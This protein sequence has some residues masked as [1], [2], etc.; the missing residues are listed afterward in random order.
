M[1]MVIYAILCG[2]E[3]MKY[4]LHAL[5]AVW[6]ERMLLLASKLPS[7]VCVCVSTPPAV[8]GP[9]RIK[10]LARAS[11]WYVPIEDLS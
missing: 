3:I 11:H 8:V 2:V 6:T 4:L 9:I 10:M 7:T 5:T 1:V